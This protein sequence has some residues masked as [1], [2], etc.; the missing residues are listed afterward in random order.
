MTVSTTGRSRRWPAA[1]T[2]EARGMTILGLCGSWIFSRSVQPRLTVG[3]GSTL[4]SGHPRRERRFAH[5]RRRRC[6]DLGGSN[7]LALIFA[8]RQPAERQTAEISERAER[9][10]FPR[11]ADQQREE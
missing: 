8:V 10:H 3:I 1:M 4:R 11:I 9:E 2:L 5:R 6:S 7:I